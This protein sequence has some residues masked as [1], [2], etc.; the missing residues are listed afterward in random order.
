MESD[1]TIPESR[2]GTKIGNYT[3]TELLGRG[4]FG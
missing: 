4:G 1:I 2:V 3:C